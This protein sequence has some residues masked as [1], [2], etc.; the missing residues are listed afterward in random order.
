MSDMLVLTD[1]KNSLDLM[2]SKCIANGFAGAVIDLGLLDG[3][4]VTISGIWDPLVGVGGG[5]GTAA[6]DT[7]F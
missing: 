5:H 3:I 6:S 4:R 1:H 7:I 2:V